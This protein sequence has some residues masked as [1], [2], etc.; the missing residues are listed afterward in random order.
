ML[1][2]RHTGDECHI[3]IPIP[4]ISIFVRRK[5]VELRYIQETNNTTTM[6]ISWGMLIRAPHAVYGYVLGGNQLVHIDRA[7]CIQA[8]NKASPV[9][10]YITLDTYQIHPQLVYVQ[11]PVHSK[12]WRELEIMNMADEESHFSSIRP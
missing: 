6:D 7:G 2:N 11:N 8:S 3:N 1:W 5:L 10:H 9:Q 12:R 4:R